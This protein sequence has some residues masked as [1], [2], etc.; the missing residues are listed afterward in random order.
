MWRTWHYLRFRSWAFD[1]GVSAGVM[2]LAALDRAVPLPVVGVGLLMAVVLLGRRARP[3]ATMV[4]VYALAPAHLFFAGSVR[5]FDVAVLIAMYSVVKYRPQLAWG[6]WAGVGASVGVVVGAA[7]EARRFDNFWT[8]VCVAGA[9]TLAVWAA[10]FGTRTRR[11]YVA[12]LEDRAASLERERDHLARLAAADE[13]AA[14]ARELHDVVAHG[15]SVMIVQADAAGYTLDSSEVR[16]HEALATIAAVGRDALDDMRRVV[17]VLR[18]ASEPPSASDRRQ[19]GLAELGSLLERTASAGLRV[20]V[21]TVGTPTGLTVT[22]E[23]TTYR[24]VQESLTNALRHAGPD[25]A[26][27]LRLGFDP[28]KVSI[29]VYDDGAA[30]LAP[31]R[32]AAGE[33]AP[34]GLAP[35]V[36]ADR[37]AAALADHAATD[38]ESGGHGLVGIRERV[39][40]HGGDLD[41][42][43]RPGGGWRVAATVPR[44]RSAA[45]PHGPARTRVDQPVTVSVGDRPDAGGVLPERAMTNDRP[46]T[47]GV[48]PEQAMMS[49]LPGP[50]G[51]LLA[52]AMTNDSPGAPEGHLD[53]RVTPPTLEASPSPFR[54]DCSRET[55]APRVGRAGTV[56]APGD[57][58]RGSGGG[59]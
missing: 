29:E 48:L 54:G 11:L 50:G 21:E 17:A 16:T 58:V 49:E 44:A 36:G 1:V 51:G 3:V 38:R 55:P 2:L 45:T 22:E 42:G 8:V 33:S 43:P 24:I 31:A 59:R 10:A 34:A 18:G 6:V 23:L 4:A 9:T 46:D 37:V 12:T 7:V 35:T 39:A 14:I 15:L 30:H 25:A 20:T 52:H 5:L 56:A 28:D 53:Q 19:I 41:V 57:G 26:V 40:V 32:R 13:R 27:T 47:G